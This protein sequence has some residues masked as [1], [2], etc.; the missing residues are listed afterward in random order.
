MK[1]YITQNKATLLSLGF[2]G[3]FFS[4]VAAAALIFSEISPAAIF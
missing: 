4:L 2:A 1:N 3:S